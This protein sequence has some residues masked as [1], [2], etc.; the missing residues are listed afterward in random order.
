MCDMSVCRKCWQ[1]VK[2]C[3][4]DAEVKSAALI[5]KRPKCRTPFVK[6]DQSSNHV[7]RTRCDSHIYYLIADAP[8]HVIIYGD[9]FGTMDKRRCS[10]Y[11]SAMTEWREQRRIVDKG[12]E[13]EI[14]ERHSRIR[15]LYCTI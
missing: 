13:H 9:R 3:T 15:S 11:C 1:F 5:Q 14:L 7:T 2:N 12:W 8:T 6:E 4:Y 10:L